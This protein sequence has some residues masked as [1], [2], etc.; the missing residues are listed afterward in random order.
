MRRGTPRSPHAGIRRERDFRLLW[1][2][3][4][5]SKLGS[6]IT[7][8]LVPL[9]A[10][11]ALG[12]TSFDV[13]VL[14][15][16]GYLPWLL[17]SLPAGVWVDRRRRRPIMLNCDA[18]SLSL[19]V[20]V[21]VAASLGV[22]SMSY[23][24][25]VVFLGGVSS[26][27]FV[28]SYRAYV[29]SI[30]NT[31]DLVEANA[32]LQASEQAAQIAGRGVAGGLAQILGAVTGMLA[33]AATFAVSALCLLRIR[34]REPQPAARQHAG[35]ARDVVEGLRFTVA[36]PYLRSLSVF[37]AAGN[38]A[39]TGF[40][41]LQIV[42]L[43]RDV[44]VAPEVVGLVVAATSVGGILGA[45]L[46]PRSAR[47]LGTARA[48]SA[49]ALGTAPFAMLIPLTFPGPGVLLMIAGALG[50][51]AGL[52]AITVIM[53]AFRQTYCPPHLLGRVSASMQVVNYGATPL[54]TLL[55][56]GLGD[57]LGNRTTLWIVAGAF[58]I[59]GFIP[60]LGP[61]RGNRD[62]PSVPVAS[63]PRSGSADDPH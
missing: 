55:A 57:L 31:D 27:L 36:D 40:L 37:S 47:R 29:P 26:V 11:T 3:E 52:V 8:V 5:T 23:L 59:Y 63:Q 6:S 62:L 15:A 35:M 33:D 25:T 58:W 32:T 41:T 4:T 50:I 30:A 16:A 17:V 49:W 21:P 45:A 39:Y 13:G 22:L 46:A 1:L 56:G 53:I 60:A 10:V 54:G 42:F 44:G 48:L 12:A 38:L 19:L 61:L 34:R 28:T 43:V 2:G 20:S 14:N 9:I 7:G 51:G 18:A 24:L